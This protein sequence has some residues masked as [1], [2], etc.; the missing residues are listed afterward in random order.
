MATKYILR[1]KTG[2]NIP[3]GTIGSN[4]NFFDELWLDGENT[5]IRFNN[6]SIEIKD[7]ITYLRG[8]YFLCPLCGDGYLTPWT[9][10]IKVKQI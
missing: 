10:P 3:T 1:W 5:R 7:F 4:I 9:S 2:V 6:G 8:C